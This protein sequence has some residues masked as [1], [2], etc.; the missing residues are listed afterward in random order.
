MPLPQPPPPGG[1]GLCHRMKLV[2]EIDGEI[3][4]NEEI[5]LRDKGRTG[6]LE[7]F[8]ITVIRFTNDEVLTNSRLVEERIDNIIRAFIDSVQPSPS[9]LGEGDK[10]GEAE[11][12]TVKTLNSD[13]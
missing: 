6:E 3:H 11:R 10:G 12:K 1:R 4:S 2:I 5:Q 7:R 9:L 13:I 8:E